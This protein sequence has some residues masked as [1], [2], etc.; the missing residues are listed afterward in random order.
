MEERRLKFVGNEAL[1]KLFGP[2]RNEV[3]GEWRKL[4][5]E[6][7]YDLYCSS[8]NFRVIKS[9]TIWCAGH[10]AR[11]GDRIR[12][13]RILVRKTEGKRPLGDPSIDGII[14]L[15]SFFR[16]RDLGAYD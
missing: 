14:M 16:S 15:K 7:L 13:C 11:M 4:H 3:T 9:K 6:D 12:E 5:N 2:K 8:S 1:R 10:V